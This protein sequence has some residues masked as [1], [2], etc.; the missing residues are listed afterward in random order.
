MF[1]NYWTPTNNHY[2]FYKMLENIFTKIDATRQIIFL[3]DF[4]ID[5][6]IKSLQ[7]DQLKSMM[8]TRN[9]HALK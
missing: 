3:G 6:F 2:T 1:R 9:V 5:M 8:Q 7:V 4:N